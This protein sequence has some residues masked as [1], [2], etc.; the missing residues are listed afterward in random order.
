MAIAA[1]QHNNVLPTLLAQMSQ[2]QS[3]MLTMQR[4]LTAQQ[5]QVSAAPAPTPAPRRPRRRGTKHCWTHGI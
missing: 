5:Q 4:Q 2:M 1:Q 3:A